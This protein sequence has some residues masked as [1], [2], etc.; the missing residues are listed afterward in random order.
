MR[1]FRR[2][3]PFDFVRNPPERVGELAKALGLEVAEIWGGEPAMGYLPSPPRHYDA[4]PLSDTVHGVML[5]FAWDGYHERPIDSPERL[6]AKELKDYSVVFVAGH[7]ECAAALE[8]R[9]G[10]PQPTLREYCVRYGPFFLNDARPEGRFG[11]GWYREEPD[12]NKPPADL[13]A[14][15][16]E[17]RE[18]GFAR[19]DPPGSALEVARLLGDPD[20][21]AQSTDFHLSTWSFRVGDVE[22]WLHYG[23]SGERVDAGP[24]ARRRLGEN[25]RVWRLSLVR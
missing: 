16:A 11:L 6:A 20:P 14:A 19:I 5:S 12:W 3:G 1:L 2:R 25:D 22:A 23:A 9:Y 15:V 8:E 7:Q 17:V 10:A 13:A 4:A 18:Q 24:I 21:V